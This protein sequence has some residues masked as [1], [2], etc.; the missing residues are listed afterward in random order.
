MKNKFIISGFMLLLMGS[1]TFAYE[2]V[3]LQLPNTNSLNRSFYNYGYNRYSPYHPYSS[4]NNSFLR[5]NYYG[6]YRYA[7]YSTTDAKRL[8]RLKTI[9]RLQRLRSNYLT[10]DIRNVKNSILNGNGTMTGYSVPVSQDIYN[11][12]GI[13]P[14]NSNPNTKT[15]APMELYSMPSQDGSRYSR[16]KRDNDTGGVAGRTGVTIIYD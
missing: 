10:W 2:K 7:G 14:P 9:R 11:Q 6:P 12:M 5:R 1:L 8:K 3:Y 16:G 4:Y 13:N 15:S